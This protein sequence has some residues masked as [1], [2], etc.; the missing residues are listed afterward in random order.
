MR[1]LNEDRA[2]EALCLEMHALQQHSI[3]LTGPKKQEETS[4][5]QPLPVNK[6]KKTKK[7]HNVK[8]ED[9]SGLQ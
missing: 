2:C 5:R 3:I 1:Q 6:K 8:N 9:D 4:P 7:K